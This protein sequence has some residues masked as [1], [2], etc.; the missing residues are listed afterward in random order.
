MAGQTLRYRFDTVEVRPSAFAVV[1]YGRQ[2][3]FEPKAIRV[4]IYLIEHRDRAV[5][6][7][8]LI[9]TVWKNTVVTDNSLT[10]IVAQIRR[11]LGDDAHQPR[12]IQTLPTLGYRF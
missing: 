4:L 12:Y 2:L 5:S 6:K 7:D 10:R 8:E 9:E 11:E 1:R 3:E